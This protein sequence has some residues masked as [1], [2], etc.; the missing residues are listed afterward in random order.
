MQDVPNMS[1]K[2][3]SQSSVDW[4]LRCMQCMLVALCV[5]RNVKR[6]IYIINVIIQIN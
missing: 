3:K 2:S 1:S 4:E 6:I 5:L